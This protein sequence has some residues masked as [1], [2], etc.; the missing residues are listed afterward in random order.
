MATD[1]QARQLEKTRKAKIA[2]AKVSL[3]DAKRALNEA[4]A[5]AQSLE[6]EQKKADAE[7][8]GREA[9]SR[10]RGALKKARA[11]VRRCGPT[12]AKRCSR[13]RGG[14]KA[15]E[16]AKRTVEKASEELRE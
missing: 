1:T 14:G 2:A 10:S 6:A 4:R 5:R 3:Q 13:G 15:V 7:A 11:D 12:R 8:K 9:E 16:D